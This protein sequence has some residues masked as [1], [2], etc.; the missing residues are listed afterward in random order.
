MQELVDVVV[1]GGG[2]SGL[3]AAI[4]AARSGAKVLLLEK[5]K[6]L[7]EKLRITGGGRCN[8]TN[9]EFDTRTLLK[10][11]G[12]AE[13][14]LYSAF[15]AH[16]VQDSLD[17]FASLGL[18]TKVEAKKRAF[19][20]SEKAEDVVNAL[21]A[22]L[23][24]LGVKIQTGQS[25]SRLTH[26]DTAITGVQCGMVTYT[27]K[28]YILATGGTSRPETGA[29]GDGFNWLS[30]L[31]HTVR[32]PSPSIT[33]LAIKEKSLAAV[34]GVTAKAVR[35][36]FYSDDKKAF[37]LDGDILFTH[38]GVSG[39]LILSNSYRVDDLLAL[40]KVTIQLDF[41]PHLA[42]KD[43]DNSI[44]TILHKN[45]AKQL[46]NV[47]KLF[48]PEGIAPYLVASLEKSKAADVNRD[49]R[50]L[51]LKAIKESR[52]TVEKLMGLE[53]A[54]VA[55]G[56]VSLKEIDTRT[57]RSKLYR[58]LFVTG[59]LLDITR[60]SGGFSLQLCWTSGFIAGTATNPR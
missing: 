31:G 47:I 43:L 32:T 39:P 38:F 29:T 42:A 21:Q 46:K 30:S 26:D 12:K 24:T 1:I 13:Q 11:Y 50:L 40:G 45:G 37:R 23:K 57:F 59:D 25:V 48:A 27:A 35:A 56:G 7:G 20:I 41:M 2:A 44:V 58:N 18:K 6:R 8:I 17:F 52:L 10:N 9:A 53:K 54:V 22:E 14:F 34:S 33:P 4:H 19:P 36:T 15:V 28:S 55:D 49:V 51:L 60:P 16:G 5:N 3:Y